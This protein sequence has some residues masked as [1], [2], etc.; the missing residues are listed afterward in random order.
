MQSQA[1]ETN[2]AG[3]LQPRRAQSPDQHRQPEEG[4]TGAA[5]QQAVVAMQPEHSGASG[6]VRINGVADLLPFL[7]GAPVKYRFAKHAA[8]SAL[9]FEKHAGATSKNQNDHIFLPNDKSLYRLFHELREVPAEQF[10][11]AFRMAAGVPMTVP[12]VPIAPPASEESDMLQASDVTVEQAPSDAAAQEDHTEEMLTEEEKASLSLLDLCGHNP[13][14]DPMGG[15]EWPSQLHHGLSL[16]DAAQEIENAARGDHEMP[17]VVEVRITGGEQRRDNDLSTATHVKVQVMEAKRRPARV[18]KTKY[19]PERVLRKKYRPVAETR[20]QPVRVAETKYKPDSLLREVRGLLFT[21]LLEG[22]RVTYKR[23]GVEM[24]GRINGQGYSCGCSRCGYSNIMN[25]CEFEQ[26]AGKSTN[27]QN[28]HIF[29]ET[30]VSLYR[31]IQPLKY[32]RLDLLGDLIEEQTGLPPNMI[33]YEKWKASFQV[34]VEYN[35]SGAAASDPCSTQRSQE[36]PAGV[37]TH[38]TRATTSTSALKKSTIDPI[39]NL[40]W[41]A[42]RRPRWQYKQGSTKTSAPTLS[43]RPGKE[44]LGLST[45]TSMETDAEETPGKN[46]A[47]PL[48]SEVIKPNFRR[49]R[50][51]YKRGSTETSAP[52]LSRIPEK[53]TSGLSTGISMKSDTEETPSKNTAGPL[54][55]EVMK[56]NFAAPAAVISPSLPNPVSVVQEPPPDHSVEPK[57]KESRTS[58]VRDNTLH[59]LVFKEGGLPEF[60]LLTYK[61]KHGEVLKQGYK[62]GSCIVCDCCNEELTPSQFED[63]AGMGKRRQPYRNIYTLE[64]LTLHELALKLQDSLNSNGV[65]SVD[66]SDIDDPPNLASSGCS[67]ERSTTSRPIIVPFKRTLQERIVIESCH[68]CGDASTTVG[69][70]SEDMIIFCNQ[71]ERPC[72]V[73]CYNNRLQEKKAPLNVL[74]EYMKFHFCCC[75]KCQLLHASLHQ[76]LNNRE[77]IRHQRSNVCWHL[78]SGMN[79]RRDV[80]HYMNQIIGIFKVAFPET[81]GHESEVIQ[82]MVTA[83]DLSSG[84]KDFR[85]VYCAVLTTSSKLVLSAAILKVRTEEVAEL[86]LV[87]T[88]PEYRNKGYFRLLL[89]QIEAHLTALNVR[90]LTAPVD[91]E[92]ASIWSK[93]LGFTVLTNEEKESLLEKHPLVMFQDLTLM[94]KPLASKQPDP[95]VSTNQ[96]IIT[97]PSD[98]MVSTNQ[99]T[100]TE[101]SDPV[102]STNQV[103]ITE[104]SAEFS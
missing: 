72:H 84:K 53:G 20:Y 27:N 87:A 40:D 3:G 76:V 15:I 12:A 13:E 49:P 91:P 96:V 61:L 18:K 10:A 48:S 86:V 21:G 67:K 19:R 98:P 47:G 23:D 100:V 8:L 89:R 6:T 57:A 68:L 44:T 37:T 103:T 45:R 31:L 5:T 24:P 17:D 104:L 92:M 77:K 51:Q 60:T 56:P 39:P 80:Q 1:V 59:P 42:F 33:E 74:G 16:I 83:M 78:L 38:V 93:K 69:K 64:G 14:S 35:D 73:K 62:R 41:S 82:D 46:T 7:R 85:G 99:V 28:D 52:T 54:S 4:A 75:Q 36:A 66:F 55:C 2:D 94:Q 30:G 101:P 81:D 70:I 9:Q 34:E 63:H 71:C 88:H 11:E 79:L 50:W 22:F 58:K 102:V 29:L 43:R 90:L 97:E 65:S 32:Q 25:A 95:V 26:H